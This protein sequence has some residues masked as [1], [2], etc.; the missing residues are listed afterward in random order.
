MVN[1]QVN[2]VQSA[3]LSVVTNHV[4]IR[5]T[6]RAM[7][8]VLRVV[9]KAEMSHGMKAVARVQTVAISAMNLALMLK[10][11]KLLQII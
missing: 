3:P 9:Q 1:V 7:N 8:L 6:N 11:T 5:V 2:V 4:L 10:A